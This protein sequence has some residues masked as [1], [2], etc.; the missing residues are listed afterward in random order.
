M[1]LDPNFKPL[2]HVPTACWTRIWVRLVEI[3]SRFTTDR[4]TMTGNDMNVF[5]CCLSAM[6]YYTMSLSRKKP[7]FSSEFGTAHL[8]ERQRTVRNCYRL[9][10]MDTSLLGS[11]NPWPAAQDTALA[12]Y[13]FIF[14]LYIFKDYDGYT[15]MSSYVIATMGTRMSDRRA[16]IRQAP[17]RRSWSPGGL[18]TSWFI[19]NR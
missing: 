15:Q 2:T 13:M 3:N 4:D 14:F 6:L 18:A 17:V 12:W 9:I 8:G 1:T 19:S 7:N 16:V 5:K 10:S 11:M